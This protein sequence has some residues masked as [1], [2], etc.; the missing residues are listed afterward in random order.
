MFVTS[1]QGI[2]ERHALI[3][4]L[5]MLYYWCN[6]VNTFNRIVIPVNYA[7]TD[8]YLSHLKMIV[9]FDQLVASRCVVSF[10]LRLSMLEAREQQEKRVP[11]YQVKTNR[12]AAKPPFKKTVDSWTPAHVLHFYV[13]S[14]HSTPAP[15]KDNNL[16]YV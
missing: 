10:S 15:G 16:H 14:S 7:D 12:S 13:C 2:E 4:N 3:L 8:M 5:H 6:G 1:L 11:A 9:S